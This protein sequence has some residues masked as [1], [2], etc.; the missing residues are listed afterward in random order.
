MGK[1]SMTLI[2]ELEALAE[3]LLNI[4]ETLLKFHDEARAKIILVKRQGIT[5]SIAIARRHE[6]EAVKQLDAILQ[7]RIP[8]AVIAER[9]RI[10]E[11]LEGHRDYHEKYAV[12]H[13]KDIGAIKEGKD[14]T[15]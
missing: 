3:D 14:V 8:E 7:V 9:K 10:G 1:K 12:I 5:D 2:E 11:W 6:G 15:K 4:S 13:F